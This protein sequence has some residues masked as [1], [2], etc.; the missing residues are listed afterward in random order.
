MSLR[1]LFKDR[2][3]FFE[4]GDAFI[5]VN[6]AHLASMYSD[7]EIS[8]DDENVATFIDKSKEAE[9]RGFIFHSSVLYFRAGDD[10]Y[11]YCG[12]CSDKLDEETY[13]KM[14]KENASEQV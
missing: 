14:I 1:E 3:V 10:E 11:L 8:F 6:D 13:F 4:N 5:A 12:C 7:K 9:A 2:L